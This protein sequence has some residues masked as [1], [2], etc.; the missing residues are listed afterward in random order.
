[1]DLLE[2]DLLEV[3]AVPGKELVQPEKPRPIRERG[4]LFVRVDL[5]DSAI[6]DPLSGP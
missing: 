6:V 3:P 4:R 1:V 5:K 2:N